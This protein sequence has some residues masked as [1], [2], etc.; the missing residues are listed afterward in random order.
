[1]QEKE[2]CGVNACEL[3]L[4]DMSYLR[5][6]REQQG[7]SVYQVAYR[8]Q[9][10]YLHYTSLEDGWMSMTKGFAKRLA[11]YYKID[12]KELYGSA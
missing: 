9:I 11:K 8:A 12:W 3:V 2:T 6:L 7:L 4:S 5:E 1:M 10:W